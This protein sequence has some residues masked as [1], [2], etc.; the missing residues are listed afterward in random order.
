MPG[1]LLTDAAGIFQQIDAMIETADE[2]LAGWMDQFL[3]TIAS[4]WNDCGGVRCHD[5]LSSRGGGSA[6]RRRPRGR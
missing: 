4:R 1:D 6:R 5:T 3:Q 2:T